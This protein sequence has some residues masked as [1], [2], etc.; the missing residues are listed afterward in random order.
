MLILPMYL[1]FIWEVEQCNCFLDKGTFLFQYE[2]I[3]LSYV[4]YGTSII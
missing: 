3:F 1:C 4:Q 2:I